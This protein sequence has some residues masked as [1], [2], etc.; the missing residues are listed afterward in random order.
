MTGLCP[1]YCQ[2]SL[3]VAPR[4][5]MSAL[6]RFSQIMV[7]SSYCER[8]LVSGEAA[9]CGT[10]GKLRLVCRMMVMAMVGVRMCGISQRKLCQFAGWKLVFVRVATR[11]SERGRRE[12]TDFRLLQPSPLSPANATRLDNIGIISKIDAPMLSRYW[13]SCNSMDQYYMS[14]CASDAPPVVATALGDS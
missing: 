2:C 3:E 1:T 14:T 9:P 8:K 13:T 11:E 6:E 4:C 12:A 10:L 7:S 5:M